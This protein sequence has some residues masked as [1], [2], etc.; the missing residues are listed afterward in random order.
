MTRPL[1]VL[2]MLGVLVVP[3]VVGQ[4]QPATPVVAVTMPITEDGLAGADAVSESVY[5]TLSLTVDYLAGYRLGELPEDLADTSAATLDDMCRSYEL[6]SI[7][8]GRV[9][10][11]EEGGIRIAMGVYD[12]LAGDVTV[13]AHRSE[14]GRAHV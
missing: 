14:I 9:D 8:F 1:S 3:P 10:R 7:I 6:D 5:R 4:D 2:I 11:A 13:E 12:A